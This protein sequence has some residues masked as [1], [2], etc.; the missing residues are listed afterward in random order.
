MPLKGPRPLRTAVRPACRQTGICFRFFLSLVSPVVISSPPRSCF[1]QS[2]RTCSE[3]CRREPAANHVPHAVIPPTLSSR[4]QPSRVLSMPTLSSRTQPRILRMAV[5]DLLFD[6]NKVLTTSARPFDCM[7]TAVQ[8]KSS[9]VE[10]FP[11]IR[12]CVH[13]TAGQIG[14]EDDFRVADDS[15]GTLASLRATPAFPP[16]PRWLRTTSLRRCPITQQSRTQT[17]AL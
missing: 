14:S 12:P 7:L 5:R 3:A 13:V 2:S 10:Q 6:A 16:C 15:P 4:R 17:N 8:E 1:A 9:V 11:I